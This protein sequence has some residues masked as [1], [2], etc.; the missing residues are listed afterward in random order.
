MSPLL[1]FILLILKQSNPL[2]ST[3][4]PTA[5]RQLAAHAGLLSGRRP[6]LGP[7]WHPDAEGM[8]GAVLGAHSGAYSQKHGA[9]NQYQMDKQ[10][11]GSTMHWIGLWTACAYV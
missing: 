11:Q 6:C 7:A 9:G 1:N 4:L 8:L 10:S 2:I 3:E 5:N